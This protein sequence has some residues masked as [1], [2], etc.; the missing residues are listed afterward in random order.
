MSPWPRF[1]AHPAGTSWRRRCGLEVGAVVIGGAGSAR[2]ESVVVARRAS[3]RAELDR[4][5]VASRLLAAVAVAARCVP[6]AAA[7]GTLRR[8]RRRLH[9]EYTRRQRRSNMYIFIHRLG[10]KTHTR[11]HITRKIDKNTKIL[12]HTPV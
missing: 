5:A 2:H 8:R 12:T 4:E 7:L 9:A 6:V 1:L 11:K 10:R 3:Q